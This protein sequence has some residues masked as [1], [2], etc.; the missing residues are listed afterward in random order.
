MRNKNIIT[1]I[2]L[3]VLTATL[4]LPVTVLGQTDSLAVWENIANGTLTSTWNEE[5]DGEWKGQN[6]S[7]VWEYNCTTDD[8]AWT[9]NATILGNRWFQTFEVNTDDAEAGVASIMVPHVAGSDFYGVIYYLGGDDHGT[10]AEAYIVYCDGGVMNYWNGTNFDDDVQFALDLSADCE[11]DYLNANCR[12]KVFWN[13]H[14]DDGSNNCTVRFKIWDASGDEPIIWMV[15]ESFPFFPTADETSYYPGLWVDSTYDLDPSTTDFSRIFFWNISYDTY[16]PALPSYQAQIACPTIDAYDAFDFYDDYVD[17]DFDDVWNRTQVMK[18][19]VNL[20][21]LT[22]TYTEDLWGDASNQ[23]DTT[24]HFSLMMT[25]TRAFFTDMFGQGVPDDF[26][27]NI[28]SMKTFLTQDGSQ[29]ESDYMLLRIDTDN[30]DNY[31]SYDYALW[32]NDSELMLYQGWTPFVDPWFGDIWSGAVFADDFGEQFRDSPY[33]L[34]D[35][36][37]N[38]DKVYNG[39][40]GERVGTD[41]CRMSISWYDNDTDVL[42]ILQDFDEREDTNPFPA[43]EERNVTLDPTFLGFN[44]SQNWLYFYIDE[45]ISGEPMADP[46]DPVSI[47]DDLTPVTSNLLLN[48]LPVLIAVAVLVIIV[49]LVFTM[50]ATKESL[51]SIMII[52]IFAIVLIQVL[53]GL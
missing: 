15:D 10:G 37:I 12:V 14:T 1:Y 2:F 34:W 20:W 53:L 5:G 28:L 47:Y 4:L 13:W 25:N 18:T 3:A 41:V 33:Y 52:T 51:I 30:N 8:W 21:D 38:W 46:E 24:Y 45:S 36:F 44:D 42:Q 9:Y 48:V 26:P 27:D 16:A 39:A 6:H 29:N 19:Y 31:D 7:G 49:G 40:T 11:V 50:G 43:T 35:V 23:N 32:S 17:L 22:T